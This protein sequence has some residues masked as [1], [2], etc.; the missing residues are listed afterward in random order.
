MNKTN[1]EWCDMTWNP[2]TGCLHNCVYCYAKQRTRRFQGYLKDGEITTENP[3]GKI[4]VLTEPLMTQ[5][6]FGKQRRAA[7]PFGFDPTFHMHRLGDPVK[8]KNPQTVFVGSM[9]DLFGDWVP[10]E[11]IYNVFA[12]CSEAPQHKYLFLTKNPKRYVQLHNAGSLPK[13]ENYWYGCT[14]TDE[15][16]LK[17]GM[18]L[19]GLSPHG[20]NTF[21]SLEP[22]LGSVNFGLM[23][24]WVIIGAETGDR[25]GKVAPEIRWIADVVASA[26]KAK[27]PV[28][29][30]DNL[31]P[32]LLLAAE[33]GLWQEGFHADYPNGL[34]KR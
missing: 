33:Y 3:H 7:L 12:S 31:K 24:D 1:I 19:L 22:L 13:G 10:D 29:M 25:G 30:K 5:D 20:F 27:V 15:K 6:Q 32:V 21:M 8:I 16:S 18:S 2:V 34:S 9:C 14:V 17:T 4:A 26:E 23:P 28:F 11:W